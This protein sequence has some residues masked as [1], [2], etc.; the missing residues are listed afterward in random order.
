MERIAKICSYIEK[1]KTFADVGCDHGYCAQFAI[2]QGL[3]EKAYITDIS[4]KSLAKAEKLLAKH[5]ESGTCIPVC[6]DGLEGLEKDCEQV[7][8]AGMGGEEI[9]KILRQGF[10][11]EKFIFQPMKNAPEL[12]AFLIESGCK[13]TA[14]DIFYDGKYYFII[15][16]ERVGGTSAYTQNELL[17]GRDSLKN[18]VVKG[19]AFAEAEK[20][21]TY[22]NSTMSDRTRQNIQKQYEIYIGVA[23]NDC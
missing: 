12:R 20:K 23:K 15:K 3:C 13:I 5:I 10:I 6:C 21:M 4:A 11:P 8:I 22:L 1:S 7:L 18:P 2:E 16:G 9:L 17:F 14:D 19:Y